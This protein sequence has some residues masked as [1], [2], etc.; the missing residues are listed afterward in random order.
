MKPKTKPETSGYLFFIA[1]L[2]N[3]ET[4]SQ[5]MGHLRTHPRHEIDVILNRTGLLRR[6]FVRW[7]HFVCPNQAKAAFNTGSSSW[8]SFPQSIGMGS[9]GGICPRNSR[10]VR[11]TLTASASWYNVPSGNGRVRSSTRQTDPGVT[12]LHD[13]PLRL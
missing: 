13:F 7:R 6:R 3:Y 11:S 4:L 9:S 2:P 5:I 8:P 10:P 1:I 12:C